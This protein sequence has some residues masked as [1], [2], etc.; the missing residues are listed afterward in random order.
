MMTFQTLIKPGALHEPLKL[1]GCTELSLATG[2][3]SGLSEAMYSR[4]AHCICFRRLSSRGNFKLKAFASSLEPTGGS[5]CRDKS[6]RRLIVYSVFLSFARNWEVGISDIL[7]WIV[8]K[9]NGWFQLDKNE[10]GFHSRRRRKTMTYDLMER[11]KGGAARYIL[12]AR[13]AREIQQMLRG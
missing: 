1:P 4:S 2:S 8:L 5:N 10:I 6:S 3:L 11:I 12:Q 7:Q 9:L 13:F